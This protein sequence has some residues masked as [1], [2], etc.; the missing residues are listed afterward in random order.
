MSIINNIIRGASSQFGREFG[1]A[2][3]NIILKGKNAYHISS[4]NKYDSRIKPSDSDLV[5]TIKNT[6]K[7]KFLTTDKSNLIKILEF[8]NEILNTIKFNGLN[9]IYDSSDLNVLLSEY[10]SKYTFGISLI[11]DKSSNLFKDVELNNLKIDSKI[12]EY[13]SDLE[14]FINY[15]YNILTINKKTRKK[16]ILL[17]IPLLGFQWFY[18]KENLSGF[19]SILLSFLII[20]LI[21]NLIALISLLIMTDENFDKKYNQQFYFFKNLKSQI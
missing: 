10:E 13:N 14:K 20:P 17:S 15:N 21:I 9:S 2:G 5:K 19:L 16:A 7:I 4:D 12:K 3:A 8:Q 6:K 18:L 11:E 1:R